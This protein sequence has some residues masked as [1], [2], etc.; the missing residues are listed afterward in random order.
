M[1]EYK[2]LPWKYKDLYKKVK[3]YEDQRFG[4][5]SVYKNLKDETQIFGKEKKLGNKK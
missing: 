3:T 4:E 5:I 1:E 2:D